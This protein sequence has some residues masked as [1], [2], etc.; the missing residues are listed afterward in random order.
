MSRWLV[1]SS[2]MMKLWAT[3]RIFARQSRVFSPPERD[4][5]DLSTASPEKRNAP[6]MCRKRAFAGAGVDLPQ[7]GEHGRLHVQRFDPVL[8]E[9]G[10]EDVAAE[11]HLAPRRRVDARQQ[12]HERRLAGAVGPDQHD[13]VASLD[14]QVEAAID[15]LGAVGEGDVGELGDDLAAPRRLGQ[16]DPDGRVVG[17]GRV[18]PLDL[19]DRLEPALGPRRRSRRWRGCDRRSP[20]SG[21]SSSA[22]CRT[23]PDGPPAGAPS[24]GGRPSSCR[25]R[26]RACPAPARTSW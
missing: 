24:G 6:S 7:A 12:L 10:G 20:A 1:G 16:L 8:G 14:L 5:T 3:V 15:D 25:C 2:I 18:D 22:A 4:P 11:R 23:T 13:L 19:V 17:L 9:V 21:G 26:S